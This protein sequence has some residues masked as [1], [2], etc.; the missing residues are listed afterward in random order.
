[1]S[2]IEKILSELSGE[3]QHVLHLMQSILLL[4]AIEGNKDPLAELRKY[5]RL[6]LNT[7]STKYPLAAGVIMIV[8]FHICL[9]L[10]E[11]ANENIEDILK[12]VEDGK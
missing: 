4:I 8:H 5:E 2:K 10:E 12:E 7:Y 6:F 11:H 9:M 3:E 1:M